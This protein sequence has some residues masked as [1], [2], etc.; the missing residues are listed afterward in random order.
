MMRYIPPMRTTV[1]LSKDVAA[2]VE[3]LRRERGIGLSEALNEIARRGLA[4]RPA[5]RRFEQQT[6]PMAARLD[7]TN[8]AEALE[9]LEG[10][11]AR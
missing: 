1:S 11:S 2:A 5:E 8:V 6:S 7:V 4:D 3:H 9:A 10:P